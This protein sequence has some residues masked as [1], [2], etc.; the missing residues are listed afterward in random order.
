MVS[1]GYHLPYTGGRLSRV[2]P[3]LNQQLIVSQFLLE[4]E[5]EFFCNY[6]IFRILKHVRWP[7]TEGSDGCWPEMGVDPRRCSDRGSD[8]E[9]LMAGGVAC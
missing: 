5:N 2:G 8:V 3:P 6:C 7:E 9:G 1:S 4:S